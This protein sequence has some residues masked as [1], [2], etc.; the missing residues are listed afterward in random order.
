MCA[1]S[2]SH[3]NK[4]SHP[5][6]LSVPLANSGCLGAPAKSQHPRQMLPFYRRRPLSGKVARKLLNRYVLPRIRFSTYSACRNT[7]KPRPAV[8]YMCKV[9][10]S[11][12]SPTSL[13]RTSVRQFC[14]AV[15]K[16]SVSIY[17]VFLLPHLMETF[18]I[19]GLKTNENIRM[20]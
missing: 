10:L 5:S 3:I 2:V 14:V 9:W 13:S 20:T 6:K 8:A 4:F 16:V 19:F 11:L 12:Y 7:L 18:L 17:K 15:S 1:I